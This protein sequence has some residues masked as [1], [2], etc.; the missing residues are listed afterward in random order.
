MPRRDRPRNDHVD[1]GG[2][3]PATPVVTS[4]VAVET[5]HVSFGAS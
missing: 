2:V 4:A 1:P 5:D 3:L